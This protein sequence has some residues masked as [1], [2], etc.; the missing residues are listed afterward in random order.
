M[1]KSP[2]FATFAP[3]LTPYIDGQNWQRICDLPVRGIVADSRQVTDGEVFVLLSI[4]ADIKHKAKT[5]IEQINSV[6][7]IS[8]IAPEELGFDA[9]HLPPMPVIH[10]PNLRWILG[11]WIQAFLQYQDVRPLPKVLAVTGTNGK[12][13]ISQL[14]TQLSELL[15]RSAGIMGTAGNGRIGHL[16]PSTHTTSDVLTVHRFLYQMAG[17][18]VQVVA[19][20]ASSHG[21]D[22]HRLASVPVQVAIFSNLSRD[23]LDYHHDM[24][25]YGRAKA[26]LFDKAY[27]HTLTHAVVNIDD[28]FGQ[29]LADELTTQDIVVWTYSITDKQ[30]DFFA[31]DIQLGLDGASFT[32]VSPLGVQPLH[33]PLLGRFNVANLLASIAGFLALYPNQFHDL[34]A[35]VRQLQGARGR[36]ERVQISQSSALPCVIVDYAHTPDALT[37]ALQSLRGHCQGKLWVVFG[38]GGDR[39]KG[40]RPL[41]TQAAL[42]D[43]DEVILTADNPRSEEPMSILA[44]MQNGITPA[45]H[46]RVHIEPDRHLAITHALSHA[47]PN[48]IVLIAGKGH[49]TYQEIQGVRYDFDDIKVAKAVLS[50]LAKS[51]V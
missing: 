33:S 42:V 3:L 34:N 50:Q 14:T 26:R 20:E 44:D 2:T 22:Q 40:K 1:T 23:H 8:E 28:E 36:M 41:M 9:N 51:S 32:L 16:T 48:D 29:R 45:Q 46:C 47:M 17:E 43:A 24:A 10:I 13:T 25:E 19:L 7:V 4:N 38:C 39:D 21:L 5:Y 11:E 35:V 49:E 31:Q 12:T 37:Q 18:G 27:F 15:G 6:A 30:A